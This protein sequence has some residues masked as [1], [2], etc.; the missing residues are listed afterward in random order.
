MSRIISTVEIKN[1]SRET[2][3]MSNGLFDVRMGVYT[4]KMGCT[5]TC[6]TCGKQSCK[7]HFGHIVLEK[8]ILDLIVLPVLP[9]SMGRWIKNNRV[10]RMTQHVSLIILLNDKNVFDDNLGIPEDEKRSALLCTEVAAYALLA[11][12]K[13]GVDIHAKVV[14]KPARAMPQPPVVEKK[15]RKNGKKP[16]RLLMLCHGEED[17]IRPESIVLTCGVNVTVKEIKMVKTIDMDPTSRPTICADLRQE[18]TREQ[19]ESLGEFDIITLEYPFTTVYITRRGEMVIELFKNLSKLLAVGGIVAMPIAFDAMYQ[20]QI[21]KNIEM[22]SDLVHVK[23]TT[24]GR[25]NALVVFTFT[26]RDDSVFS[27]HE[28]D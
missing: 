28:I 13:H 19:L 25:N 3:E 17:L 12:E 24:T 2:N 6:G 1:V 4:N 14:F 18:L 20:K 9:P 26:R 15:K 23:S 22:C 7:G 21:I 16:R 8:P 27:K 11:L 5:H 10:D